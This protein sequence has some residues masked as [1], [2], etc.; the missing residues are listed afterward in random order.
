M[1]TLLNCAS[2]NFVLSVTTSHHSDRLVPRRRVGLAIGLSFLFVMQGGCAYARPTMKS[3]WK[4]V[5]PVRWPVRGSEAQTA[6]TEKVAEPSVAANVAIKKET[7]AD[8]DPDRR[9]VEGEIVPRSHF[10]RVSSRL[11]RGDSWPAGE[12]SSWP[13]PAD[14]INS[15]VYEDPGSVQAQSPLERLDAALSDDVQQAQALPQQSLT[16]MEQRYRAE[17]LMNRAKA[18]L[19]LGQHEQAL[20][21][22]ELAQQLSDTAQLDF[23]PD[24]DRPVDVVW[25]IKGQIEAAAN[26]NQPDSEEADAEG[27]TRDSN[28]T[29]IGKDDSNSPEQELKELTRKNRNWTA[30]FRRVRKTASPELNAILPSSEAVELGRP[31]DLN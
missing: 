23:L 30:V 10:S 4:R 31:L 29:K 15:R 11:S 26:L 20:E 21:V 9:P 5:P 6:E 14:S 2:G 7:S 12:I 17:L 13:E 25:R 28:K 19:A 27:R 8:S 22:A 3:L 1:D 18:L 16:M 24:E